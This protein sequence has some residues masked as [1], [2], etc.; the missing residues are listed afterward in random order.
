MVGITI[1]IWEGYA[2]ILHEHEYPK[3]L[4][5]WAQQLYNVMSYLFPW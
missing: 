3:E 4:T 1:Q 2:E 5:T